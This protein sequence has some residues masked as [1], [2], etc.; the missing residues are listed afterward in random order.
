MSSVP[1]CAIDE[2]HTLHLNASSFSAF[3]DSPQ[4]EQGSQTHSFRIRVRNPVED[5]LLR[6]SDRRPQTED[7]FL[8]GFSQFTQR[9]DATSKRGYQQVYAL[10]SF[11]TVADRRNS[12]RSSFLLISHTPHCSIPS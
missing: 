8:Y 9:R 11:Q 3:P 1:N 2:S 12:V 10:H 6:S 5:K 7:G 4:F